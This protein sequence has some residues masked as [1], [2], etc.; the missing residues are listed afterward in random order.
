MKP[1]KFLLLLILLT[2]ICTAQGKKPII[3]AYVTSW[4]QVMPD[5]NYVT[6]IN[7][8]FGHVNKTFNGVDIE[9][10]TR[11]KSIVALKKQFP[12]LKVALSIG[13]WTSGGF[14]EM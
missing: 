1:I 7:Y 12:K 8:A 6:H 14:S 5:P 2:T 10:E 9:K 11:L 3:V 13:G 4:T